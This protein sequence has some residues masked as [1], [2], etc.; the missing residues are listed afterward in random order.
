MDQPPIIFLD[1]TGRS[2]AIRNFRVD[3]NHLLYG[4]QLYKSSM[5]SPSLFPSGVV[6]SSVDIYRDFCPQD[7]QKEWICAKRIVL[8]ELVTNTLRKH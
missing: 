5:L 3:W 1:I 7:T 2:Q 4:F 6:A 8:N